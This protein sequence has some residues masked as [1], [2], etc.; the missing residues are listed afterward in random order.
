MPT[1]SPRRSSRRPIAAAVSPFP[2]RAHDAARH[3]DVLGHDRPSAKLVAPHRF[4]DP[5]DELSII[6]RGVDAT[7]SKWRDH[8]SEAESVFQEPELLEGLGS[9]EGGRVELQERFEHPAPVG[10]DADVHQRAGLEAS[11]RPGRPGSGSG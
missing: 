2:E 3:E 7:P 6:A 5:P 4:P 10:V 1:R 9:F 11:D 8:D